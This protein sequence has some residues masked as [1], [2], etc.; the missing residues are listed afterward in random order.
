MIAFRDVFKSFGGTPVLK[1]MTLELEDRGISCLLGVSGCGK[2]TAL[3]IASCLA[4]PD[5]GEVYIPRAA[6]GVG[7]QDSRLLPWLTTGENLALALNPPP[8]HRVDKMPV[9]KALES[10]ALDPGRVMDL[11]PR[12]LSGGMA[13][14]VCIARALL[15]EPEYLMLDEPFAALDAM[16]R[17]DLQMMLKDLVSKKG[18]ACLFVTHDIEEAFIIGDRILA[19]ANGTITH[20]Y[21]RSGFDNWS[22]QEIVRSQI[23]S[24]RDRERS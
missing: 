4:K 13:Q 9:V 12:E 10:V 20:S 19:M 22:R 24:L 23:L 11:L 21:E 6:C 3:R 15:R 16:T 1:G 5:Q 2:S 8:G 7:F 17:R 14:R 18:I